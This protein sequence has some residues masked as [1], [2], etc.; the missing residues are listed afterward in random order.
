V[1]A[2]ID[3]LIDR[4][5]VLVVDASSSHTQFELGLAASR[6]QEVS[7]RSNRQPLRLIPVVTEFTQLTGP[8]IAIQAIKRPTVLSEDS[9]FISQLADAFQAL[10]NEMGIAQNLEPR[11]LFE[12]KEYRAAVIAAMTLLEATL[13]QRLN[14]PVREAVQRPMSMRQLVSRALEDGILDISEQ[15]LL[16]WTKVRNEAVHSGK[17]ISRNEAKVIVEGVE[18]IV[19]LAGGT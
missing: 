15:E 1:S 8:S 10:A 11:R 13:R 18:A 4:A 12:A 19:D 2:K 5:A 9:P 6:A 17:L 16:R 14:K 3:T 7:T